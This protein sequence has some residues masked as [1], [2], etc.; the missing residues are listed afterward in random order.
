MSTSV[1][2][3]DPL[4]ICLNCQTVMFFAPDGQ[5]LACDQCGYHRPVKKKRR[6]PAD[7]A[8][9]NGFKIG[10]ARDAGRFQV[11]ER[12]RVAGARDGGG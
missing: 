6:R 1:Q 10:R 3:S 7:I 5:T 2:H 9:E 11:N 8:R 12:P 4:R